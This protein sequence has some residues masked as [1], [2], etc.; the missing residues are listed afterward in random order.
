MV[1][2]INPG[3]KKYSILTLFLIGALL[4]CVSPAINITSLNGEETNAYSF[5]QLLDKQTAN[6]I[7]NREDIMEDLVS[8]LP[9]N[10][11]QIESELQNPERIKSTITKTG[12]AEKVE[13]VENVV[14][15]AVNGTMGRCKT[16]VYKITVMT[17]F[18]CLCVSLPVIFVLIGLCYKRIRFIF[19]ALL[20]VMSLITL[21]VSA[22]MTAPEVTCSVTVLVNL[23]IY[24][25]ITGFCLLDTKPSHCTTKTS[26]EQGVK[27]KH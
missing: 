16:L 1:S 3:I 25:C 9:Y 2:G 24:L 19:P 14:N 12:K 6:S 8:S 4:L 5:T 13:K 23:I 7:I 27:I 10:K 15:K 18:I 11:K 22:N 26:A 17:V 21:I 20:A